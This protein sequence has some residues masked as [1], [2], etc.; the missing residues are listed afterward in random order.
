MYS[1]SCHDGLISD[2][3]CKHVHIVHR[4]FGEKLVE[5]VYPYAIQLEVNTA[6]TAES[7]PNDQEDADNAL[8][9]ALKEKLTVMYEVSDFKTCGYKMDVILLL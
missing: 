5:P 3:A 9:E 7:S 6:S 1:C 8:A 4:R 2:T